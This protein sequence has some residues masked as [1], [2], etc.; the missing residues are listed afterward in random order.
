MNRT[1]ASNCAAGWGPPATRGRSRRSSAPAD[2]HLTRNHEHDPARGRYSLQSYGQ[3]AVEPTTPVL[4]LPIGRGATWSSL[5]RTNTDTGSGA[6][7]YWHE[8]LQER[9]VVPSFGDPGGGGDG[10][11]KERR[12]DILKRK[13][14]GVVQGMKDFGSRSRRMDSGGEER[15]ERVRSSIS[16]P[17]SGQRYGGRE[18]DIPEEV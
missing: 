7:T 15:R 10:A 12:W 3:R 4:L 16:G 17:M 14:G 2:S 5:A 1:T 8:D 9:R 6:R 11:V 13:W 18:S